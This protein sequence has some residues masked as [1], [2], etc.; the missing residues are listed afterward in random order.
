MCTLTINPSN[1]CI[2]YI[3]LHDANILYISIFHHSGLKI[4][5]LKKL[6]ILINKQNHARKAEAISKCKGGMEEILT[7]ENYC[8]NKQTWKSYMK[9]FP[10]WTFVLDVYLFTHWIW[11]FISLFFG[12]HL[13][14][15]VTI[16]GFV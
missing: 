2:F 9:P 1:W 15:L 6:L 4:L 10:F 5:Y 3:F 12:L 14:L 16:G 13:V 8:V 11:I 7:E